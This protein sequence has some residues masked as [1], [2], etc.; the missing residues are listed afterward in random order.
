M[1]K[2]F[3][4]FS[5]LLAT[6]ILSA[7]HK[8]KNNASALDLV[9][10]SIYLYSK[11][12]YYWNDGLPDYGTFNP[13]GY[14]GSS[15]LDAVQKEV[16]AI[17]QYKINPATNLPYEYS[18]SSPGTAKYS[19]IDNGQTST[20]LGGTKADYGFAITAIANTDFRVRYVYPGS[21]AGNANMHRADQIITINTRSNLDISV[22]TDYNFVVNALG[23]SP[24]SMTLRRPDNTTYSV[25]LTSVTYTA[26]PVLLY[27]VLD[28][29]SGKKVGYV[30]FN[31]FTSPANATPKLDE[32]FNN[33]TA[34]GVT[35][36]V[37]DLRYNGGGYVSTS[38]YLANLIVPAAKSGG[39][40]YSS[41]FN[42]TLQNNQEVLLK[43]QY[44]RDA[45]NNLYNYGQVD[46]SIA[47]NTVKFAKKGSLGVS[48]VFFIVTG[49]TASAS[50]LAINN[51]RPQMDVKLIGRTTYGKPVGFFAIN[52]SNYQLY[53]PEF[54]TKNSAGQGGYYTGMLPGSTDYPGISDADDLTKDFGDPTEKLL[55]HALN[56]VTKGTY[57]NALQI[58]STG[59]AATNGINRPLGPDG[60]NGMI[61][62]KPATIKK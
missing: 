40:M 42:S 25:T 20:S 24:L 57:G 51:L 13:R 55:A 9:R 52:I 61:F 60:F 3:Y 28:G 8:N 12:A 38:E 43:K 37:V 29:G 22:T 54:E 50:E 56:Y 47:G 11:E 10:D 59:N 5:I 33:F 27:K 4:F 44:A 45:N 18:T 35:D 7:C 41:Y 49:S 1:K 31:T 16:N 36:L 2:T 6:G 58:Q 17:S 53:V 32:A 15:D 23:T 14:S 26:N 46:Y 19:F 21:P 30:V 62:D 48:R 39:T 34:N